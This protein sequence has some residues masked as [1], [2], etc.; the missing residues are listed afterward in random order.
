MPATDLLIGCAGLLVLVFPGWL[1][2]KF[3]G[4]PLPCFAGFILGAVGL[5]LLI[6]VFGAVDFALLPQK[7]I[8]AWL[9]AS[10]A[11]ILVVRRSAAKSFPAV[12]ASPPHILRWPNRR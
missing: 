4:L 3:H 12:P 5:V 6:Q 7:V 10:L 2:A 11:M 1:V 8:P 9:A